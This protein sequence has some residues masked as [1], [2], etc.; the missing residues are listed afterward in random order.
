MIQM[1]KN[2]YT[3]IQVLGRELESLP[4]DNPDATIKLL[5]ALEILEEV[6]NSA[7]YDMADQPHSWFKTPAGRD[8][9]TWT[10]AVE[11]VADEVRKALG[12]VVR[13]YPTQPSN[14]PA[15]E[16][17]LGLFQTPCGF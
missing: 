13:V 10:T 17:L 8:A 3:Q 6:C 12:L 15:W 5:A 7:D 11:E 9:L 2:Q 14:L 4:A 1:S 16:H